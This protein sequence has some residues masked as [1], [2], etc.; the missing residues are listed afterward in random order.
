[1]GCIEKDRMK[2]FQKQKGNVISMPLYDLYFL[3]CA[4]KDSNERKAK[5]PLVIFQQHYRLR[6]DRSWRLPSSPQQS[7]AEEL[8]CPLQPRSAAAVLQQI[9]MCPGTPSV[10]APAF[11]FLP[12]LLSNFGNQ[13]ADWRSGSLR[14][15]CSI[16]MLSVGSG[17]LNT[18]AMEV[19]V[20][21]FRR[22]LQRVRDTDKS[23]DS[24]AVSAACIR[25]A[26]RCRKKR[27]CSSI[28]GFSVVAQVGV[29]T[30][31]TPCFHTATHLAGKLPTASHNRFLLT[32]AGEGSLNGT[33]WW[34]VAEL[35]HLFWDDTQCVQH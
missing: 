11:H 9:R 27:R 18:N 26:L 24:P 14:Q 5:H 6:K 32:F 21:R 15:L 16:F 2:S 12:I 34:L 13:E 31:R 20:E 10:L 3:S 22:R 33:T 35:R 19:S 1:M 7:L 30:G 29:R 8:C 28:T 25:P 4:T 23:C 17:G